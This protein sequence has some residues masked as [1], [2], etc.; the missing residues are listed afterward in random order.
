M[1]WVNL[2]KYRLAAT[3]GLVSGAVGAAVG[4]YCAAPDVKYRVPEVR[5][6]LSIDRSFGLD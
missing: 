1:D 3:V 6:S 5:C 4:S 2:K